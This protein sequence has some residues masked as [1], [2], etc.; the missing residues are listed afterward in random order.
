M[1]P[2]NALFPDLDL[3]RVPFDA[4]A[5]DEGQGNRPAAGFGGDAGPDPFALEFPI[6]HHRA[7]GDHTHGRASGV[8]PAPGAGDSLAGELHRHDDPGQIFQGPVIPVGDLF[9]RLEL[10]GEGAFADKVSL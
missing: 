2:G 8:H 3:N 4:G 9:K 1:K 5:V 6:G 10:T 7:A